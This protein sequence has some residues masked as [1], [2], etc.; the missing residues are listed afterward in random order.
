MPGYMV[1]QVPNGFSPNPTLQRMFVQTILRR[2]EAF[3][4]DSSDAAPVGQLTEP[5]Q[6][7]L[8]L[9]RL[10]KQIQQSLPELA[11]AVEA[12]RGNLFTQLPQNSQHNARQTI[13][14]DNPPKLIFDEQVE[15]A[16]QPAGA[17]DETEIF[18]RKYGSSHGGDIRARC[19]GVTPLVR[20]RAFWQLPAMARTILIYALA[21]ALGAAAL[22]WLEYRYAV[23]AFSTEIYIVLLA[24]LFM[25]I[26]LWAGRKLTQRPAPATFERN[27][28][29]ARS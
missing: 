27:D 22:E 5:E 1:Y 26:G 23:R 11:P 24:I 21:L 19:R 10:Q 7:W 18:I 2:A 29:A 12:A 9:T 16:E 20:Y 17:L 25:A 8:A 15:A 13:A 3:M 4:N 28:A 14:D 6:M